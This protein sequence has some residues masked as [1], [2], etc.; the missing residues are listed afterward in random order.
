MAIRGLDPANTLAEETYLDRTIAVRVAR[1]S[2]DGTCTGYAVEVTEGSSKIF[3]FENT[4]WDVN[5]A[6]N[7]G[8]SEIDRIDRRRAFD[9]RVAALTE[10]APAATPTTA[11]GTADRQASNVARLL[12]VPTPTATGHC[13]YCGQPLNRRG[14]CEECV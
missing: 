8:R 4:G 3:Y 6:L 13:H 9:A 2:Q 1:V 12:G 14:E 7:W 11:T 5:A 10:A